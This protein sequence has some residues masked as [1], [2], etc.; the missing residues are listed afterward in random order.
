MDLDEHWRL[1]R[2]NK[3]K[4][5]RPTLSPETARAFRLEIVQR[6]ESARPDWRELSNPDLATLLNHIDLKTFEARSWEAGSV[7]TFRLAI[8]K[9]IERE[10][11]NTRSAETT[12]AD[13]V[14]KVQ[15]TIREIVIRSGQP[16]RS[17]HD[18]DDDQTR[19]GLILAED[20][21]GSIPGLERAYDLVTKRLDRA[22]G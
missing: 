8:K 14:R 16:G 2:R 15:D 17:A 10:N 13:R 5:V 4:N 9:E 18:L 22:K 19:L 12:E 6:A 3:S 11:A 20:R 21:N 7:R 1:V